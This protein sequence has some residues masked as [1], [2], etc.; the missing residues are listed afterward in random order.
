[1]LAS[2]RAI[3]CRRYSQTLGCGRL[4]SMWQRQ[5]HLPRRWGKA[6]SSAAGCGS[7]MKTKSAASSSE[8]RFSALA[9]LVVSYDPQRLLGDRFRSPCRALWKPLVAR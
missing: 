2:Y 6:A 9:A 5:I 3:H 8:R 1:M 4:T 7:W